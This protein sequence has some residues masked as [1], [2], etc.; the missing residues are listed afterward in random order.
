MGLCTTIV[1]LISF[2]PEGALPDHKL[3]SY[4]GRFNTDENSGFDTTAN[5]LKRMVNQGYIFKSVEKTDTDEISDWRVG[6]RGKIE[7]GN[8]GIQGL[9]RTVY[10]DTVPDDL[11]KRMQRSLGMEVRKKNENVNGEEEEAPAREQAN[12]DPGPNTGRGRGRPRRAANDD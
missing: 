12:G 1:S 5:T 8:N 3:M 9:V 7:I 4:L 6:P 2:S 11:E 10:G